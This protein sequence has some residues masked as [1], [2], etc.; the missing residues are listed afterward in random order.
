MSPTNTTPRFAPIR[1][2][3]RR[4]IGD[5]PKDAEAAARRRAQSQSARRRSASNGPS[6]PRPGSPTST[7]PIRTTSGRRCR[8][9]RRAGDTL[10]HSRPPREQ[11]V[12]PVEPDERHR[13]LLQF[14]GASADI[15]QLAEL[16]GEEQR[17]VE[18]PCACIASTRRRRLGV[19]CHAVESESC[20]AVDVGWVVPITRQISS[21]VGIDEHL[22]RSGPRLESRHRRAHRPGDHERPTSRAEEVVGLTAGGHPA[23]HAQPHFAGRGRDHVPCER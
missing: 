2:G 17:R 18:I 21:E 16:H 15:G 19:C 5:S 6:W 23:R 20:A 7:H 12:G 3:Q 22:S 1:S 13:H 8:R 10:R 14:A 11:V 4:G 9:C